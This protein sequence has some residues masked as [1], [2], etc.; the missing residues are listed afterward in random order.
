VALGLC[1]ALAVTTTVE[2]GIALGLA[3]ALVLLCSNVAVS[4]LRRL[5]SETM[6]IPVFLVIAAA[7]T[8]IVDLAMNG[9]AHRV[10]KSLDIF[11]PLIAVNCLVLDRACGSAARQS[12]WRSIADAVGM[13]LG[14]AL[15]LCLIGGLR[16]V[17]G[18]GSLTLW[19][20]LGWKWRLPSAWTPALIMALAPGGFLTLGCLIAAVNGVRNRRAAKRR[21]VALPAETGGCRHCAIGE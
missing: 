17:L 5:I 7:F 21:G 12:V 1:P 19:R 14:F 15:V 16:E 20:D 3:T 13:G 9:S 2:N 10:H 11:V 4:C 18:S 6:R 8:T